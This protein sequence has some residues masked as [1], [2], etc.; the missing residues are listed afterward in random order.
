MLVSTH[1]EARSWSQILITALISILSKRQDGQSHKTWYVV[2]VTFK[3]LV[4]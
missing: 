2:Q 4:A 3:L 1:S